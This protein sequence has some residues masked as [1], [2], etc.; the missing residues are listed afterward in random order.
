[1]HSEIPENLINLFFLYVKT[2]FLVETFVL[3]FNPVCGKCAAAVIYFIM[4]L[5]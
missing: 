4:I 5:L 3:L 1:M 2:K